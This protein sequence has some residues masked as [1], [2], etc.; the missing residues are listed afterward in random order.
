LT[1]LGVNVSV[2]PEVSEKCLN[3]IGICFMFAPLYHNATA[4]V[5]GIRRQLG[6]HTT[7]NLLGPLT[8][9]AGAPRQI[10]GVWHRALAE[11]LAHTLAAL[12]SKRAWVVHG[13]D[14]LDEA[15]LADKTFVAEANENEVKTFEISPED[16][17][18]ERSRLDE[19]RGGDAEANAKIIHSVL[20]GERHDAARYL[21]TIN[22]A[23]ALFVG[24]VAKDFSEAARLAEQSIDSGSAKKK[25]DELVQATTV[26]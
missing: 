9:P 11:P 20:T 13:L 14:G 18:L 24:G 2:P 12:G 21:I 5:V 17:G 7:F 8:N 15:T 19:L 6:V 26:G 1:A 22:A 23:S 10:I 16:F 3:E 25:L 4:R